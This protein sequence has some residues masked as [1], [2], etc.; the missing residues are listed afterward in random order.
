MSTQGDRWRASM[1]EKYGSM[2]EVKRV[3]REAQK[4]SRE[5]YKGTG[6]FYNNSELASKAGK[7]SAI[8]K[9]KKREALHQET[10]ESREKN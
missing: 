4:K 8:A 9:R 10:N 6:G 7:L 5:T 2:E 1:V 3:M